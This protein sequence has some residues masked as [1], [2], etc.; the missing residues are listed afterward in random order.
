[1]VIVSSKVRF[2]SKYK[3]IPIEIVHPNKDNLIIE[4]RKK[5][6]ALIDQSKEKKIPLL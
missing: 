4:F 1:M 6:G 5:K 3:T 2:N